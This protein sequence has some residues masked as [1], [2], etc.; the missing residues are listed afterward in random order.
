MDTALVGVTDGAI[1]RLLGDE[2]RRARDA[3]GLTRQQ[4]IDKMNSDIH[5]Q[6]LASYENGIRQCTVVRLVEICRALGVTA[7]DVLSLSLQRAKEELYTLTLR[8]DLIALLRDKDTAFDQ[9]RGW[10]RMRIANAGSSPE[11]ARLEPP[12]IREMAFIFGIPR[13]ELTEYL[14]AFTPSSAPRR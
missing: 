7:P 8:V 4:L 1:A 12:A 9:V 6:T 11:V 14:A 2:L 13:A 5:P 10:A 3:I